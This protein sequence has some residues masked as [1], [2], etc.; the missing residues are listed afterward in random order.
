MLLQDWISLES[1]HVSGVG[2]LVEVN[3]FCYLIRYISPDDGLSGKLSL[4]YWR[5]NR[6]MLSCDICNAS[7]ASD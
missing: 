1:N 6:H 7:V 4:S 2:E 5:L 3:V